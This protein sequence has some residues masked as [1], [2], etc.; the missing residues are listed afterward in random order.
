MEEKKLY[1]IINHSDECIPSVPTYP[2]H[3]EKIVWIG[4]STETLNGRYLP[5]QI[6]T[7]IITG[8]RIITAR[9]IVS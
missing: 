8:N 6:T 1:Q 9:A 3:F 2:T 4:L 5:D 7:Q